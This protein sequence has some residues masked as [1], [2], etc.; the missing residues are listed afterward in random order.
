V[1]FGF[2]GHRDH[3]REGAFVQ[4]SAPLQPDGKTATGVRV[5]DDIVAAPGVGL[6]AGDE[7]EGAE[8]FAKVLS[9][10]R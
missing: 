7:L 9:E 3:D 4:F 1:V 10:L 6:S 5:P 8:T 2:E